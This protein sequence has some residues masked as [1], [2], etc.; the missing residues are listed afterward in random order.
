MLSAGVLSVAYLWCLPIAVWQSFI[1]ALTGNGTSSKDAH[2]S[3]DA[4]H[5]RRGPLGWYVVVDRD[6]EKGAI[7]TNWGRADRMI[8]AL[9][10]QH[11]GA[12]WSRRAPGSNQGGRFWWQGYAS[13][14]DAWDALA[15]DN[16]YQIDHFL[17]QVHFKQLYR[18]RP[19]NNERLLLGARMR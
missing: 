11:Q 5:H 16:I 12:R 7:F 9:G 4:D 10:I 19:H 1:H 15:E 8:H 3:K 18:R 13:L 6:T 2:H 14:R 17:G